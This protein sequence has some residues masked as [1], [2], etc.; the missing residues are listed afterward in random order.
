M[1]YHVIHVHFI[2]KKNGRLDL[3]LQFFTPYCDSNEL[4]IFI[5]CS[6]NNQTG[7]LILKILT[8]LR[9]IKTGIRHNKVEKRGAMNENRCLE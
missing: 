3:C 2:D 7:Q 6:F 1:T 8:A 4:T 9:S 5:R